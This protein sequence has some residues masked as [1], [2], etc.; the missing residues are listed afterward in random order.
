MSPLTLLLFPLAALAQDDAHV[1]AT[2]R[3]ILRPPLI[4]SEELCPTRSES[5]KFRVERGVAQG[6]AAEGA[7]AVARRAALEILEDKVCVGIET[8]PR[9]LAARRNIVPL[10]AG[11]WETRGARGWA[12][13]SVA[14]EEA[15]LNSQQRDLAQ[16]DADLSV[17]AQA[18]F[19]PGATLQILPPTWKS[20]GCS[21]GEPG[22]HLHTLL[23]QK[24][25]GVPLAARGT[26]GARQ[27][28]LELTVAGGQ[29][30]LAVST[31][32]PGAA[33]WIP[34]SALT[35]PADLFQLSPDD[36]RICP[37]EAGVPTGEQPGAGGLTVQLYAVGQG[38][39]YCEGETVSPR[40]ELSGPARLR[41]YSVESDGTGFRVW[42]HRAEDD[43]VFSPTEPPVL[44]A[45]T[46]VQAPDGG[47]S[48]LVVAAFPPDAALDPAGERLCFG[49]GD[50]T[51]RRH[52][53]AATD[54][55]A[56]C[57][58]PR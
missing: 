33:G 28:R 20:T 55:A 27:V 48:R 14:I 53:T 25:A 3:S 54:Q 24:L 17:L 58:F 50:P 7:I 23:H 1:Y 19:A 13:A 6:G 12:C 51:L 29:A 35:F 36:A 16:L 43:R 49:R 34:L 57:P 46:A 4:P 40:I 5:R 32:D 37:A 26:P 47:D 41:L 2:D 15:V 31:R 52:A 11:Q 8:S 42:P 39:L 44:P 22:A 18:L 30:A 45:F 10:G 56:A 9:C 21:A 38:G